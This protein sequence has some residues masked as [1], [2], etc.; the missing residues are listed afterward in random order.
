ML[1]IILAIIF[2]VIPF[3]IS[4]Y[5]LGFHIEC[6]DDCF[7]T[8]LLENWPYLW[9]SIITLLIAFLPFAF[10]IMLAISK[11]LSRKITITRFEDFIDEEDSYQD[12]REKIKD[13][14]GETKC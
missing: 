2:W 7:L 5:I 10:L 9:Q 3:M 14:I 13:R 11:I 6:L 8:V 1:G 4:I 12:F